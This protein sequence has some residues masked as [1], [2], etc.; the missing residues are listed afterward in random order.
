MLTT[1]LAYL[2]HKLYNII[3][4]SGFYIHAL[5]V[6]AENLFKYY[7]AL[8]FPKYIYSNSIDSMTKHFIVTNFFSNSSFSRKKTLN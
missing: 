2:F 3:N 1:E 4:V 6:L 5:H 8:V 7:F